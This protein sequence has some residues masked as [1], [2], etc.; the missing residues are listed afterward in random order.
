MGR[1]VLGTYEV[2]EYEPN[3]KYG[4]KTLSGPV[5][6]QT[7]FTFELM[8]GSTKVNITTKIDSVDFLPGDGGVFEKRM[9]KQMKE[10]LALLK[11]LLEA[12]QVL[13]VS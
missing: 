10:N 8:D 11:D 1:R 2:T 9:K 12:K 13:A 5:N 7:S 3:T 6:S 4:Y